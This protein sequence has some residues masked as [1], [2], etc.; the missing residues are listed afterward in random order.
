MNQV[1]N[2]EQNQELKALIPGWKLLV[3]PRTYWLNQEVIGFNQEVDG[4]GQEPK[5]E[6]GSWKFDEPG[7]ETRYLIPGRF[8]AKAL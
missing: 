2:Q 3:Y 5:Q 6:P 1:P 8:L 4:W 7:T